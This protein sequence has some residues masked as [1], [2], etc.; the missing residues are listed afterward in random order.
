MIF[1]RKYVKKNS[2]AH[3]DILFLITVDDYTLHYIQKSL[4][5]GRLYVDR[6]Y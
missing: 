3:N 5:V 6:D 2:K 1:D 4:Y